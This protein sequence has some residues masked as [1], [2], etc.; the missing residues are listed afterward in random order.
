MASETVWTNNKK[1][2][3]RGYNQAVDYFC[4][5]AGGQT[6]GGQLDHAM[7]TRVWLGGGGNTTTNGLRGYVYFEMGT[8]TTA[9]KPG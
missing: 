9:A 2:E 3:H 6:L 1:I 4:D 5:Q 8:T 7:A